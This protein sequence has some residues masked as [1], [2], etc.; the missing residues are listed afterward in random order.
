MS[1]ADRLER[2]CRIVDACQALDGAAQAVA[3]L[4]DERDVADLWRL[5]LVVDACASSVRAL[6]DAYDTWAE[7]AAEPDVLLARELRRLAEAMRALADD[8]ARPRALAADFADS[9]PEEAVAP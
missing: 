8:A 6:A 3:A 7:L 1:I 4:A 9:E 2:Q 5:A